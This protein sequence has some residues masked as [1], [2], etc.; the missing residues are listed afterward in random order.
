MSSIGLKL[1][2]FGLAVM[3]LAFTP[4]AHSA[5]MTQVSAGG[6]IESITGFEHNSQIY[7]I[8]FTELLSND[9][10]GMRFSASD[11]FDFVTD[12]ASQLTLSA[13]LTSDTGLDGLTHALVPLF[14]TENALSYLQTNGEGYFKGW[15]FGADEGSF[16]AWDYNVSNTNWSNRTG[17]NITAVPLPAAVYLFGAAALGL[18]VVSRRRAGL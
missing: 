1:R 10:T 12:L 6:V 7:N 4:L 11:A 18:L 17:M 2:T 16:N 8:T 5:L 3:L 15:L 14:S 9:F 13:D